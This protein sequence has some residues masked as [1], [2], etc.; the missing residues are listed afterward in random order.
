MGCGRAGWRKRGEERRGESL[1]GRGPAAGQGRLE[2][3]RA[4]LV[5][6]LGGVLGT[7]GAERARRR[8]GPTPVQ[9]EGRQGRPLAGAQGTALEGRP[10]TVGRQVVTTGRLPETHSSRLDVPS[11]V[12]V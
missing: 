9:L 10:G 2:G 3:R 1:E 4:G 5:E 11:C 8:V 6:G 7:S 12:S